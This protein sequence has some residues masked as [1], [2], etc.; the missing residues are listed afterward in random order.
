MVV[1]CAQEQ[2]QTVAGMR[3]VLCIVPATLCFWMVRYQK[4]G[5]TQYENAWLLYKDGNSGDWW[6]YHNNEWVG[7]FPRNLFT[8]T[9]KGIQNYAKDIHYGGEVYDAMLTSQHTDA[10]MGSGAFA[11]AGWKSAAY[12][13]W[14]AY[15][16]SI[17]NNITLVD[18]GYIV[19]PVPD[20]SPNCYTSFHN[21][22]TVS[23]Y[24]MYLGGPGFSP[25]CP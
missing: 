12:Q 20:G 21:F 23:N 9:T 17:S 19:D 14:M 6:F 25:A 2:T 10:D 7:R 5:G 24:Y 3:A 4:A 13:R 1:G 8:N 22:D 16:V 15:Y 18:N 11:A